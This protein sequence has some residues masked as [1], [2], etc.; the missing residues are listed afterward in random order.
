MARAL[1]GLDRQREEIGRHREN[2]AR[3]AWSYGSLQ[4]VGWGESM[5]ST[6]I[7]FDVTFTTKP[8]VMYGWEVVGGA[9]VVVAGRYPRAWGGVYQW[10]QDTKGHFTGVYPLMVVDNVSAWTGPSATDA[11]PGY[12]ILHYFTFVGPAYK[13]LPGLAV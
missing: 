3:D 2:S 7:L 9:A 8:S 4:T 12:T 11:G 6:P 5:A 10:L 13:A 1:T